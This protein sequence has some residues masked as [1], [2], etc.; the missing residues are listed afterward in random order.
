MAGVMQRSRMARNSKVAKKTPGRKRRPADGKGRLRRGRPRVCRFCSEHALWVDYK[1]VNLLAR[2]LNDRGRIKARG[3]TGT[4]A[5]HQRD[6]A[7]AIKTARELALL[8]YAVRT[9]A[10]DP[11]D[12][13]GGSRRGLDRTPRA[14]ETDVPPAGGTATD[15]SD[16]DAVGGETVDDAVEG[17]ETGVA[18]D[19][20]PSAETSTVAAIS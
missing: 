5:Q 14:A 10:A 8:P 6:V 17:L 19:D 3:A 4:C 18:S 16:A 1:D 7:V 20:Q 2:F 11:A 13:R 9:L 15:T 12:R